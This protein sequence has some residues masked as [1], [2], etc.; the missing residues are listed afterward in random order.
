MDGM[1]Q[2]YSPEEYEKVAEILLTTYKHIKLWLFDGPMGAGK[3]TFIRALMQKA[4]VKDVVSSP[5]FALV[6][7]YERADG[8][9]VY[10]LDCY[11]LS[12]IDEAIQAGIDEIVTSGKW[13]LIEWPKIIEPLLWGTALLITFEKI[14]NHRS[15]LTELKTY[16]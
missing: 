15:V 1:I 16:E 3:T 2:I 6:N 5:T 13:C 10:H 11:R 8:E 4:G 12:G 9:P 7:E 14:D